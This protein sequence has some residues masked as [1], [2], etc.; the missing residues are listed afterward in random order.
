MN[1]RFKKGTIPWNK[2]LKGFGLG[3]KPRFV[4]FGKD[5]PSWKGGKTI[6]SW[7]Y[8]DIRIGNKY[9]KE[10]RYVMEQHLGRKLD[11]SEHIHHINGD[12]TDNRLENLDLIS[13]S[14][15]SKKHFQMQEWCF[16]KGNKPPKHRD[17][18]ICF[19]CSPYSARIWEKTKVIHN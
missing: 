13:P 7:G 14:L 3:H 12:R 19:R 18:C 11:K 8:I 6:T 17:G 1:T 15:H 4:A 9:V 5:N 2:G 16:K 10:H